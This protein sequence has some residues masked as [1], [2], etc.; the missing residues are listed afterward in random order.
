[1]PKTKRIICTRCDG[2][3]YTR[4]EAP[5]VVN[6]GTRDEPRFVTKAQGSGCTKCG[7]LGQTTSPT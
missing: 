4:A 7:G 1:M 6:E 2:H 3:G 5:V